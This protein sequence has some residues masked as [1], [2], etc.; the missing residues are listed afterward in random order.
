MSVVLRIAVTAALIFSGV[1]VKAQSLDYHLGIGDKVKIRVYE[2]RQ[3]NSDAH[4]WAALSGEFTVGASGTLFL[5]LV[6]EIQCQNLLP[7]EVALKISEKL[8][9]RVGL[10]QKPDTAIE[11]VDY[12]PF[13]ILGAVEKPG[14]YS[15][16]PGI[17]IIQA[18]S[19]AGGRP[20]VSDA[21]LAVEREAL[22]SVGDVKT[23]DSE[24][25]GIAI[26][27][28]RLKAQLSGATE[29]KIP[30]DVTK[31]YNKSLLSQAVAEENLVLQS[32]QESLKS[33]ITNLE[34]SKIILSQEIETL[35]GKG[36]NLGKQL[37]LLRKDAD[38]LNLLASKGLA[39]TSRQL[40]SEQS[41]AQIESSL[42]DVNLASSR[43]AQD[44]G[45][46]ERDSLEFTNKYRSD[47]A[48]EL[49]EAGQRLT[50]IIQRINTANKV[51]Q[52][53]ESQSGAFD[54]TVDQDGQRD[55]SFSITRM[56]SDQTY[57][58]F[59]ASEDELIQAGDTVTVQILKK[60]N[61]QLTTIDEID[62]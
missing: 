22:K 54:G 33:Q 31:Y 7:S 6:G 5:P 59:K 12:R 48:V 40:S 15:F 23:L 11:V 52:N 58:K 60:R 30:D 8:K 36:L 1:D 3:S 57:K 24:R 34:K 21:T 19:L 14:A 55:M 35:K 26:K 53:F 32:K 18:L 10:S 38:N 28:A 39:I 50:N 27:I 42:L 61:K 49:R 13:Y 41:I 47:A 4:E 20:R 43:A 44:L 16:R 45:K 56:Q 2:W 37:E 51:S 46:S 62:R 29:L 17:T 9:E 25:L